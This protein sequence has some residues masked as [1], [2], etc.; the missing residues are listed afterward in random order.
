MV[1]LAPGNYGPSDIS[2]CALLMA[3]NKVLWAGDLKLSGPDLYCL[4]AV[5]EQRALAYHCLPLSRRI[6]G[7][8]SQLGTPGG[9][10]GRGPF[11]GPSY[12]LLI[13]I[14]W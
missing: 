10:R 5:T 6:W 3:M 8:D 4:T 1:Y 2:V 12:I 11:G 14:V 13:W 7:S 9:I